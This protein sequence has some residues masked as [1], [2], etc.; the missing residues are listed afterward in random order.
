LAG[1]REPAPDWNRG[2][3]AA[4]RVGAPQ[5]IGAVACQLLSEALPAT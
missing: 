2:G 5:S 3:A 1:Q 4:P